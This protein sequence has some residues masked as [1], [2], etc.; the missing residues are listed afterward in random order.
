MPSAIKSL[1]LVLYGLC[2]V[3]MNKIGKILGVSNV[4]VLKWV[5]KE[6][7]QIKEPSSRT[8]SGVVMIDEMWHY[9]NGK[10]TRY[11]GGAPLMAYRVDLW[12]GGW[13]A[14]VMPL[15]SLRDV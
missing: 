8:D 1:G 11:G 9:I 14:V 12:D 4:A 2:G 13:V 10:K 15:E 6:A 7:Q 5:R 3:S